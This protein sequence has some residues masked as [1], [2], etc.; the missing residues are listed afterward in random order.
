MSAVLSIRNNENARNILHLVHNTINAEI[1][2][3]NLAVVNKP[4]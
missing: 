3:L 2:R 4:E 1:N